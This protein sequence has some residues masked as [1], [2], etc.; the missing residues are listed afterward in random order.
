[1]LLPIPWSHLLLLT[2]PPSPSTC[3]AHPGHPNLQGEEEEEVE[4]SLLVLP[5]IGNKLSSWGFGEGVEEYQESP[6]I[7]PSSPVSHTL[8]L[9]F[10]IRPGGYLFFI[11]LSS[12]L[13][14]SLPSSLCGPFLFLDAWIALYLLAI[15]V[16]GSCQD[17]QM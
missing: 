7:T 13:A 6:E 2:W 1:M 9:N 4:Q 17:D 12:P 3:V 11:G 15:C 14:V 10:S 16:R 8:Q 5:L